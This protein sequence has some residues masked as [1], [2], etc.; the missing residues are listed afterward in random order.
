VL[1]TAA[2]DSPHSLRPVDPAVNDIEKYDELY[3]LRLPQGEC[4][5]LFRNVFHS[6]LKNPPSL[7]MSNVKN[8][9]SRRDQETGRTSHP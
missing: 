9:T 8:P 7:A 2:K 5:L 1:V 3:D 4:D 6:H